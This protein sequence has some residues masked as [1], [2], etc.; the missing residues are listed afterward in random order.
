MEA[1]AETLAF[2]ASLEDSSDAMLMDTNNT[3]TNMNTN[4]V[5][6]DVDEDTA[7][8]LASLENDDDDEIGI[9]AP[10]ETVVPDSGEILRDEILPVDTSKT[11]AKAKAKAKS[12]KETLKKKKKQEKSKS[13]APSSS[14]DE[15]SPSS[16]DASSSSSSSSSSDSSADD[17]KRSTTKKG[18][19][20]E[21]KQK[22]LESIT[23]TT[24]TT[25]TALDS[26]N[27]TKKN[28][29]KNDDDD[30]DEDTKAFLASLEQD[31][32]QDNDSDNE[33]SSRV[34][35]EVVVP[36]L[37]KILPVTSVAPTTKRTSTK[38]KQKHKNKVPAE[39]TADF[40]EEDDVDEDTRAFL[41]SLEREEEAE[42]QEYAVPMEVVSTPASQTIPQKKSKKKSKKA[43][44]GGST[45]EGIKAF[46]ASLENNDGDK[47]VPLEIVSSPSSAAV[48]T[49][50]TDGYQADNDNDQGDRTS[51]LR[52]NGGRLRTINERSGNSTLGETASMDT[53]NNAGG[54]VIRSSNVCKVIKGEI[55]NV[56][57]SMRTDPQC[58]NPLRFVEEM[59]TDEQHP[60]FLR[61]SELHQSM[62]EW[63]LRHGGNTTSQQ[64]RHRPEARLYLPPFC[65]AIQA[66]DISA[67]VTGV[68]LQSLQK[69]LL[70]GFLANEGPNV[71]AT[72][73]DT[74]LN[75]TFEESSSFATNQDGGGDPSGRGSQGRLGSNADSKNSGREDDEQV[76]LRLLELSALIVRSASV[77]LK[78]ES[79]VG[80]LDIC[81][82]VSHRA[83]RASWLLK[84][85][86]SDS[87]KQIVLEV[88]S[89]PNLA[90]KREDILAKLAN[91]LDPNH[92]SDAYVVN[93]LTLVNFALETLTPDKLTKVEIGILKKDLCKY[94]LSW[95]TTHDLL[96]LSLTM[97]VI[98]NLFQTIRN[99]LKV[100][101]E[102]FL[103]SVHLRIL[104]HS[105]NPEE[106]EVALE[107]LLE[108]CREPALI[109][110]L[111]LNY[112]CDVQC[113]NLYASI[114]N[115]LA[116]VTAPSYRSQEEAKSSGN[117]DSQLSK[118]SAFFI[119][120]KAALA[121]SEV[122]MNILCV[123]AL[124][125]LLTIIESIARRC[126]NHSQQ[127]NSAVAANT[128]TKDTNDN[129]N[130]SQETGSNKSSH[131]Y[132]SSV[133]SVN[134]DDDL[135]MSEED[136]QERKRRKAALSQ[137]AKA[138]NKDPGSKDWIN[139][140]KK[141]KVLEET[142]E[143]V[144]LA[145]YTAPGLDKDK[146]GTY[147]SKG[148]A[149]KY[150]FHHGVR[151]AFVK[152]FDF[153]NS[154]RF[155]SALR[156][157][158]HKFRLPGEAQQIDRL[159]DTF[160]K[161][162]FEQQGKKSIFKNSDAVFVLA[163]ST[164]MLN[165][166]LHNPN[167][168]NK[169]RMTR[170][171]FIRNNRG[172]NAGGDLP[173]A[174][175]AW[176]YVDIRENELQVQREVGE[177][178]RDSDALDAGHFKGAWGDM[179]RRNV[180]VAVFT[181]PE[182]AHRSMFEAGL[183]EKDMFLAIAQ[184]ALRAISSAFIRSW[185][186]RNIVSALK[187]LEQ[188]AKI[189]TFFS[190][191]D[192][193]ND[194]M[195]FL[196]SQGRD[197]IMGCVTLEYSGIESGAP[198]SLDHGDDESTM[199][200]MSIVDPDSPVPQGLLRV[201]EISAVDT[202]K[203]ELINGAAAYRGLL[204]LNMGL[205]I[206]RTL[207]PRV[208]SAWPELI[209][210][211][212]CLR[213]ARALPAGL[214]DLDD[215]ADSD[216]NVFPLSL[217]AR[218]S[219]NRVDKVYGIKPAKKE[220]PKQGWL[221]GVFGIGKNKEAEKRPARKPSLRTAKLSENSKI[222]RQIT[223]WTEI[224]KFM[225]LGPHLR[226]QLVKQSIA[227]L[228]ASIDSVPS[229]PSLTYEQYQAFALELAARALLASEDR[230]PELFPMFLAK[231][232]SLAKKVNKLKK[233]IPMPFLMERVIVTILRSSIHMY[234][235]PSMRTQLWTSLSLIPSFP[236]P[237]LGHIADRTACALAIIW[238]SS[239]SLFDS[240]ADLQLIFDLFSTLA[241]FDRGRRL[242]F[243]GVASTIEFTLPDSSIS[244][245]LEYEDSIRETE[246][247]SIPACATLQRVLLMFIYGEYELDFSLSVPAIMC[248]EKL[249]N[250]T[251]Q[252]MLIN[253]RNDPAYD[254]E[255]L[256]PAVPDLELWHGISVAFYTVCTNE[257]ESISQQGLEACQRHVLVPD[258]TE[259][260]DP[261]WVALLN[262]MIN[263]QSNS[264]SPT[265]R[266]NSL[267]MIAQ[268][269]VMVFPT[270]TSREKNWK[271]LTELTKRV[272]MVANENMEKSRSPED[273]FDQTVTI[274]THLSV[275]LGSP[276]F[277]GERRYCKWA[278]DLFSKV[279]VKN[280]AAA[281]TKSTKEIKEPQPV[282]DDVEKKESNVN[283]N[284]N[285][286]YEKDKDGD[287]DK[288]DDDKS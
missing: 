16:S 66:F 129:V 140:G 9:D 58:S 186:D 256:L 172:I 8:F 228:L 32:D 240:P 168:Q 84:S 82:H 285:K 88:F 95:S 37:H 264:I 136:L 44:A 59:P 108:F 247:L 272:V 72:I 239:F 118:R 35:K 181:T 73:A 99:H 202:K 251:V 75:C 126:K 282:S 192:I 210:V 25:R 7:A 270:M 65:A 49:G 176:L 205:R 123:Q 46:L 31:N 119:A 89:K 218:N 71:F 253:T 187:G 105:S 287:Q 232:E 12:N 245:I 34:V 19:K 48:D 43:A 97:R 219:K 23:T 14:S 22:P 117:T 15:G 85:A 158:L 261:K 238:R 244:N 197:Y 51:S 165:T 28:A 275:Q 18:S 267:S 68:A 241:S 1:D 120:H 110:D 182:K 10:V 45:D 62:T 77:E 198:I 268:L 196:L 128:N 211:F 148:P 217:F 283:G 174:M 156:L 74:L 60:I 231:F 260:P 249:Y 114:C 180:A 63:E 248:V 191:D 222:L 52:V 107:S 147:L 54:L 83:K 204:A 41:A 125:C 115:S 169:R 135:E 112:D 2:L 122:P 254:P 236:K 30:I 57:N 160:S 185:D 6:A 80:L 81:L 162:Y 269:M 234:K 229:K 200:S 39:A 173:K 47:G 144:A 90:R 98:F 142:A 278:S 78:P 237:F 151:T 27:I 149:E 106:R 139:L 273:L 134:L 92:N 281:T 170:Q 159:M 216:G 175:L 91:L 276:K 286:Q 67:K 225:V 20:K 206:V 124:Q 164:I 55:H 93:S 213:D 224:E 215:F 56:L 61:F 64:Q 220:T 266:I 38:Q 179:L 252:L 209:E 195:S 166:D 257:D 167:I 259:I 87:M 11:E 104:E 111:Y 178:I 132:P 161:E 36:A 246:T 221:R 121:A 223:E 133:G 258:I 208:R 163:F 265:A 146:M 103:T 101:L 199:A 184:P 177:F 102:V 94:L 53:N 243:D 155:A 138:F 171:Q 143:S 203:T 42:R 284:A 127:H 262:T 21:K 188:M 131:F 4:D 29:A 153:S 230:A 24:I 17:A 233:P 96:I 86:A 183:H 242:I 33:Y 26:N 76:V 150:P 137:V 152:H 189:S 274:V 250:H 113:S 157:F 227:G 212:G 235:I 207:F 145:L 193:L 280:G 109:K 288:K 201:R 190:L 40:E 226:L 263:K 69:F 5:A 194:I 3:S 50:S 130:N 255:S 271:V 214:S 79:V 70:Y 277:G 154:G 100:P 116:N 13:N 141:A 279:L